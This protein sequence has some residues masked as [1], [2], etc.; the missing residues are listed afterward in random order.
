MGSEMCIRDRETVAVYPGDPIN[1]SVTKTHFDPQT[2][3]PFYARMLADMMDEAPA[4]PVHRDE[5]S[6]F[7]RL[8]CDSNPTIF[9]PTK[10]NGQ[11]DMSQAW[12]PMPGEVVEFTNQVWHSP[13]LIVEGSGLR[14]LL[15]LR[16]GTV[17][18]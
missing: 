15:T 6:L 4:D 5:E 10:E 9:Y 17:D 8:A 13:P 1:V 12:Q 3:D 7:T 16:I 18:L 11:A 2:D 14:T